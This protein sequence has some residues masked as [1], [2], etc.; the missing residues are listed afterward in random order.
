MKNGIM[1][2]KEGTFAGVVLNLI[3]KQ[4]V[5]PIARAVWLKETSGKRRLKEG[6]PCI[7]AANHQS[8]LDFI[9]LYGMFPRRHVRFLAAEKFYRSKCS[10]ALMEYT[11]Q[12][13][14]DRYDKKSK[15]EVVGKSLEVLKAREVLVI[16]PQGT[17]SR[18]GRIERTYTG[19]AKLA[20]LSGAPVLPVGIRGAF[21]TWPPHSEKPLFKKQVSMHFGEPMM[22]G[23]KNGHEPDFRQFCREA[24]N[25]IMAKIAELSGKEYVPEE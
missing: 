19:V 7:V 2:A 10:R 9:L 17:R 16:F 4:I 13:R 8:F 5:S 23:H 12:I 22:L 14:V 3:L 21:R 15:G 18:S 20:L 6:E 25:K 11:G 1:V 24:T